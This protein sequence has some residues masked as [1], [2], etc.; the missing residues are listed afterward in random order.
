M[1]DDGAQPKTK[2]QA[3]AELVDSQ[4]RLSAVLDTVGEGIITIDSGSTIVMVNRE[5]ESIWGYAQEELVE[6]QLHLLM[7][8]QYRSRHTVGLKRYLETGVARVIGQRMQLEGLR[9]DGSTFPLE[10]R[11][12]KTQVGPRLLFTAAVRDITDR[13]QAERALQEAKS[14][15]WSFVGN[16][17]S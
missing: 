3:K 15:P 6:K 1:T 7:P 9:K 13:L 17:P 10:I 14:E 16:R 12:A 11:M 8:E 2:Q 5:A 4:A